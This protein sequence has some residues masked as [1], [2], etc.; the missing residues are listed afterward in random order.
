MDLLTLIWAESRRGEEQK[1]E[2]ENEVTYFHFYV[3]YVKIFLS[4]LEF[5]LSFILIYSF[6]GAG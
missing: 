1:E 6:L 2:K 4:S 3:F 5:M